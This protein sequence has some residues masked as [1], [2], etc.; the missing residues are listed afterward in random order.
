[1][2]ERWKKY[3]HHLKESSGPSL[4]SVF[5]SHFDTPARYP[6]S[7][8]RGY[9][10]LRSLTA[11]I[12]S[13][14]AQALE[15]AIR[16]GPRAERRRSRLRCKT[17]KRSTK[18]KPTNKIRYQQQLRN[19]WKA[20]LLKNFPRLP[21]PSDH[22]WPVS[23]CLALHPLT[24]SVK[25]LHNCGGPVLGDALSV[26][27]SSTDVRSRNEFNRCELRKGGWEKQLFL[28]LVV[29]SVGCVRCLMFV[30]PSSRDH[31]HV[32]K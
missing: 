31:L 2:D 19:P 1:M 32:P 5:F 11:N 24:H 7:S 8:R 30:D 3:P 12:Q 18:A 28:I 29:D 16:N 4:F 22:Y 13:G 26:V 6:R 9:Q 21:D 27:L 14:D 20:G 17:T 15:V 25:M 23:R 10:N